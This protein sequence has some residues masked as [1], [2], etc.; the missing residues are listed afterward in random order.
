MQTLLSG[1]ATNCD[2]GCDCDGEGDGDRDRDCDGGCDSEGDGE[3]DCDGDGDGAPFAFE[4]GPF[5]QLASEVTSR[6]QIIAN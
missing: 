4:P 6:R 1:S 5:S 2:G 3:G